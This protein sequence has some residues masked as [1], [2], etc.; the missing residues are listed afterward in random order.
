MA[1]SSVPDI[2]LSSVP[3]AHFNQPLRIGDRVCGG[4]G[5]GI[6]NITLLSV[7]VAHFNQPLRI[8]DGVRGRGYGSRK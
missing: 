8:E 5:L 1:L 3:V 6:T 2:A 7:P 4:E